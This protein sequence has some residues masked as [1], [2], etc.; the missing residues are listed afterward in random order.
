[1]KPRVGFVQSLHLL[2]LVWCVMLA[3]SM[4][5]N[6]FSSFSLRATKPVGQI[7]VWKTY[8]LPKMNFENVK[9]KRV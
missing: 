5:L 1:M 9:K 3:D 8:M 4:T 6:A 7:V 2:N